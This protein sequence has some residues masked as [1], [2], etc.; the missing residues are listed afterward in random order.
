[1]TSSCL[2]RLCTALIASCS[3]LL[4]ACGPNVPSTIKIGVAQPLSGPSAARGK[5]LVD[6]VKLAAAEINASGFTIAG[7][8]VKFEIVVMD[9]KADKETAKAVAKNLVDQKVVAVIGHLNSDITEATIPIYKQGNVPQLFT[10]SADDLT[11]Q[12]EGN[13]FRLV[14]SDALQAKAVASYL[15]EVLKAPNAAIIH[16]DTAFGRPMSKDVA[17]EL[18]KRNKPVT[19]NTL[20][21][22]DV[23]DFSTVIAKLKAAPPGV[24]V[25]VLRDFQLVPLFDQMT[26]AGLTYIPV[27]ATSVARTEKLANAKN[28]ITSLFVTSGALEASEFAAGQQFLRKFRATYN[29]EPVWAAHYA[30]DA[31]YMLADMM[32]RA[33]SIEPDA[34]RAKLHTSDG[35]A[36][37]T[38]SMRFT[39]TGE[40]A[41]GAIAVYRLRGTKWDLLMRSDRW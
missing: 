6:G 28:G 39:E 18:A 25:A 13:A 27:I 40:Q 41:Y 8:P 34:L 37:V 2:S 17:D 15:D 33:G 29:A 35:S 23:T 3:V 16:E 31:T 32:R 1:M 30:Y 36:P 24:L 11:R 12:G 26:A 20:V 5:D 10:S 9:D 7:K 4:T 14:A 19:S 22:S 38:S 21:K